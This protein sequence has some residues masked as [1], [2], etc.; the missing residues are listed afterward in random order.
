VKPKLSFHVLWLR[1][2]KASN[3]QLF[4]SVVFDASS[5]LISTWILLDF[6]PVVYLTLEI[7][8]V[9]IEA[10]DKTISAKLELEMVD[11]KMEIKRHRLGLRES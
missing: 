10:V 8:G 6:D 3:V 9:V 5:I 2:K 1:E 11:A 4:G 7:E